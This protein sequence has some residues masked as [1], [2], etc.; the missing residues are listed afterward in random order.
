MTSQLR[1]RT[2]AVTSPGKSMVAAASKGRGI[3]RGNFYLKVYMTV[4]EQG[5]CVSAHET[6]H[7][8]LQSYEL[9]CVHNGSVTRGAA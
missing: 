9:S 3:G 7:N 8:K 2:V 1:S 6:T 5:C 4:I